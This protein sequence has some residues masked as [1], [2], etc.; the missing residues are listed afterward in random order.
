MK[1]ASLCRLIL[2]CLIAAAMPQAAAAAAATAAEPADKPAAEKPTAEKP[3]PALTCRDPARCRTL[4]GLFEVFVNDEK[5]KIFLKLPDGETA[6][7]RYL[8][9]S[10]LRAGAGRGRRAWCSTADRWI[11]GGSGATG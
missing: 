6:F 3:D 2:I 10:G 4:S 5:G 8:L 7:G 11:S 9:I 1:F